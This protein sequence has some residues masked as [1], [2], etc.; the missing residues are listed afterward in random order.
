M[1]AQK[2]F[3]KILLGFTEALTS[4]QKCAVKMKETKKENDM[5]VKMSLMEGRAHMKK[6]ENGLKK[7]WT[8]DS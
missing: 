1:N 4:P 2:E 7:L 6:N 5:D 8:N 3:E